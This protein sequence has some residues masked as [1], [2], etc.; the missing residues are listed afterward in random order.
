[1]DLVP[2]KP[3]KDDEEDIR[4][5]FRLRLKALYEKIKA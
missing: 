2:V 1:M 5:R 3:L 4:S